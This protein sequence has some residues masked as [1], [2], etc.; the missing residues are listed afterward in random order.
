MLLQRS[1]PQA[2]ALRVPLA[3]PIVQPSSTWHACA[4]VAQIR[5]GS[6][7]G[8]VG[9]F[10][11]AHRVDPVDHRAGAQTVIPLS[12]LRASVLEMPGILTHL[13]VGHRRMKALQF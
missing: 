2:G 9:T 10:P 5:T 13:P 8:P 12:D 6:T 4:H 11:L 7:L 1:T 3:V